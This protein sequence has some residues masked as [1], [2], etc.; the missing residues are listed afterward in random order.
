MRA[1]IIMR[2]RKRTDHAGRKKPRAVG[3]G[4]FSAGF[5]R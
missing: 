1:H 3:A 5:V 4:L 2:V